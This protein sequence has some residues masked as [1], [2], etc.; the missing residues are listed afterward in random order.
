MSTLSHC[1]PKRLTS[2]YSKLLAIHQLLVFVLQI[3]KRLP[4]RCN[5]TSSTGFAASSATSTTSCTNTTV[6]SFLDRWAVR[7]AHH[8]ASLFNQICLVCRASHPPVLHLSLWPLLLHF[9]P[10][11]ANGSILL[12]DSIHRRSRDIR[13][14]RL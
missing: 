10:Q 5:G 7:R 12:Q 4:V 1:S 3:N 2:S 9:S 8:T 11:H 14:R 6:S 13:Y